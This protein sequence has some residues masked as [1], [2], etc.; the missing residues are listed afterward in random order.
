VN[1]VKETLILIGVSCVDGGKNRS[2]LLSIQ[3]KRIS[4][5]FCLTISLP[6]LLDLSQHHSLLFSSCSSSCSFSLPSLPL[7]F[8]SFSSSFPFCVSSLPFSFSFSLLLLQTFPKTC[9]QDKKDADE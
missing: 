5:S 9:P 4:V 8:S 3:E 2:S 6:P 7:S 1:D